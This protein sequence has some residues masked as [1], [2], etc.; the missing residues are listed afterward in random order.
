MSDK[1]TDRDIIE[2][3]EEQVKKQFYQINSI[4]K[5]MEELMKRV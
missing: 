2:Y 3:I 1:K 4:L 5:R